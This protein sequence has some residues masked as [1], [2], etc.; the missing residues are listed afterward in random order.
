MKFGRTWRA[1]MLCIALLMLASP[2]SAIN[3]QLNYTYDTNNFFGNAQAK[4]A[5]EAAASYYSTILTDT[6]DA[7]IV[8]PDYDS[9]VPNS[10][11]KVSWSWEEHF[12]NP[13]NSGGPNIVVTHPPGTIGSDQYIVYV[14][15]SS[16]PLGTAGQGGPGGYARPAPTLTGTNQFTAQDNTNIMNIT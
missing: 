1:K 9:S 8:P 11:G 3:I 16:L 2:A 4:A 13:S 15:G 6:F 5:L 10:T 14:G 12:Q 7:I